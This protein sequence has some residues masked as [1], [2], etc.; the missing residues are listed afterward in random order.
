MR[1]YEISRVIQTRIIEDIHDYDE[2]LDATSQRGSRIVE[3]ANLYRAIVKARKKEMQEYD[4][5]IAVG[6]SYYYP[7]WLEVWGVGD[8]GMYTSVRRYV[9]PMYEGNDMKCRCVH[10]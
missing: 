5:A 3:A 4:D 1:Q 2:Y 7:D 8:D 9:L 10:S 6:D